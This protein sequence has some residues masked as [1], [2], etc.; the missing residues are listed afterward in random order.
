[1]WNK[2]EFNL[3]LKW[4]CLFYLDCSCCLWIRARAR[5]KSTVKR[6]FIMMSKNKK[7]CKTK[8]ILRQLRLRS[9]IFVCCKEPWKFMLL[10]SSLLRLLHILSFVGIKLSLNVSF[11]YWYRM[12]ATLSR[13]APSE[14][15]HEPFSFRFF[16]SLC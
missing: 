9:V 11:F 6:V 2:Y 12:P 1:M 16:S 5:F 10:L 4:E 8:G 15:P 14:I 7:K 3:Q 13:T